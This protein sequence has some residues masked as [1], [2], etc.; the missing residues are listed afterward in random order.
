MDMLKLKT[1]VFFIYKSLPFIY[2]L[3][4]IS[5]PIDFIYLILQDSFRWDKSSMM[6]MKKMLRVIYIRVQNALYFPVENKFKA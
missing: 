5:C 2:F 3:N 1:V 4:S 6:M